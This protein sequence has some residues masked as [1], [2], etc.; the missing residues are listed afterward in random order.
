MAGSAGGMKASSQTADLEAQ[1][2]DP[3]LRV[4]PN[5]LRDFLNGPVHLILGG[6]AANG[7]SDGPHRVLYGQIHCLQHGGYVDP[8]SVTGGSGRS[9]NAL[10]L[11][12][13]GI[14]LLALEADAGGV[15]QSLFGV[16]VDPNSGDFPSQARLQ[17]ITHLAH[18]LS[19]AFE[20]LLD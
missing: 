20:V 19:V 9:G 4:T 1:N 15:G 2:S 11:V 17:T 18:V 14:G 6:V 10:E 5:D 13:D 7:K 16:P 12:Q 8:V 3:R